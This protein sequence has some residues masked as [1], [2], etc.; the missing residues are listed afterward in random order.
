M[1]LNLWDIKSSH[2]N[3]PSRTH[4][5]IQI[6]EIMQQLMMN[7]TIIIISGEVA[8]LQGLITLQYTTCVCAF[9]FMCNEESEK[10]L[11][12]MTN[13]MQKRYVHNLKSIFFLAHM[14]Q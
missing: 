6:T 1:K 2:G 8:A 11:Q 12:T 4:S 5:K 9:V 7:I 14:V 3:S 13:D 10:I